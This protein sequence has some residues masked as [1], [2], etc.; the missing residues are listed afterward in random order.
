MPEIYVVTADAAQARI[1]HATDKAEALREIKTIDHPEGRLHDRELTS[2]LPGHGSNHTGS[3]KHIMDSS[4]SPKQQELINFARELAKYL[5]D[6]NKKKRI[7]RLMLAAPPSLLGLLRE[8]LSAQ[9]LE[10]ID[11]ELDKN[12]T[13]L[14]SD[15]L[16]KYFPYFKPVERLMV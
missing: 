14:K 5:N 3:G 13:H 7:D 15:E 16:R 4:T 1:L 12:L 10:Q 6:L 2:D 11:I 9:V 8:N